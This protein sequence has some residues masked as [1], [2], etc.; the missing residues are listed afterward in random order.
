MSKTELKSRINAGI[1][2]LED[3]ALPEQLN[4]FI[5]VDLPAHGLMHLT[6]A[7]KQSINEGIA[8]MEAGRYISHDEANKQMDEWL[9][10]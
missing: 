1:N 9:N 2:K 6:E 3:K 8:D 5:N 4:R 7:Q 10:K